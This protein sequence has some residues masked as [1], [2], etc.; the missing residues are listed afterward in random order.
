MIKS[1]PIV[2]SPHSR[3]K[4]VDRG[5]SEEEVKTAIYA[6]SRELARKGRIMFRKNFSFNSQWRGKHYALKQVAPV[7]LEEQGKIVVVTVFVYYF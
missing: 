5:A 4:M 1:T 6:G 2:F 7:V 3:E